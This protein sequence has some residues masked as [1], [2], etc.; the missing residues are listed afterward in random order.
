ME[1]SVVD[2][3]KLKHRPTVEGGALDGVG[4]ADPEEVRG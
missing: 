4:G 2:L 1:G 3:A